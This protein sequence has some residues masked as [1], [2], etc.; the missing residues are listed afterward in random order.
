MKLLENPPSW[1][2]LV[3]VQLRPDAEVVGFNRWYDEEHRPA[4]LSV[5]G[6]NSLH[7]FKSL[8]DDSSYLACYGIN[9]DQVFNEPRYS[10]VRGFQG[11]DRHVSGFQRAV[12]RIGNRS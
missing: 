10:E 7:R 12:Y 1:M 8:T 5:P 9:S 2:Y 3:A 6:I 4:L 11:W